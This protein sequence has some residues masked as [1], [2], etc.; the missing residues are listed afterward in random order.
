MKLWVVTGDISKEEVHEMTI[1][2]FGVY[3]EKEKAIERIKEVEEKCAFANIDEIEMNKDEE[4][5]V[6]RYEE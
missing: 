4:K 1:C 3:S 6:G 2:V 5:Y